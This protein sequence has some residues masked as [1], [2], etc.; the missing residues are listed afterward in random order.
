[1]RRG[2]M[3]CNRRPPCSGPGVAVDEQI[4]GGTA[5]CYPAPSPGSDLYEVC[6]LQG[7]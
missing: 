3:G 5:L 4:T 6:F 2:S 1:L 7:R